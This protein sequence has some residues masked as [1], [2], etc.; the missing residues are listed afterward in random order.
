M[1]LPRVFKS[2]IIAFSFWITC[3]ND[4]SLVFH[5][6]FNANKLN[7]N[8]NE[9][10]NIENNNNENDN[11]LRKKHISHQTKKSINSTLQFNQEEVQSLS[12]IE[13]EFVQFLLDVEYSNGYNQALIDVN[14]N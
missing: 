4:E 3:I 5:K 11:K 8:H 6:K 1:L 14:E 12:N 13:R 2:E 7:N 9:N 10:D